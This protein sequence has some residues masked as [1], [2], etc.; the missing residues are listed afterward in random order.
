VHTLAEEGSAY[1][2]ETFR[3]PLRPGALTVHSPQEQFAS[4]IAG[5]EAVGMTRS[6]IAREAHCSRMTVWRYAEGMAIDPKYQ[7]VRSI[8]TLCFSRGVKPELQKTR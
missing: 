4:M 3:R 7:T 6:E 1:D 5:L 8:E 2:E